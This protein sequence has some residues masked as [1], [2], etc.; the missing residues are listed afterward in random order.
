MD[1]IQLLPDTVANQIAAGE[2]IERPAS[3]IKELVENAIDAEAR[4]IDVLVVDA[5]RTLIKVVDDGKGMSPIDA[6]KSFE[7]HATSKIRKADDLFSLHTMGFRGEALA[8]IAAVSQVE[9]RTRQEEDVVGTRI[10]IA[11]SKV[12]SQEVV[13]CP[14]GSSFSVNNIFFNIPA[15]RKFLKSDAAELNNILSIFERI[16]LV[17]PDIAF[18]FHIGEMEKYNLRTCQRMQRIVDIF[19]GRMQQD[20]V[21]VDVKTSVCN[22]SGFVGKPE[23]AKKKA[24]KQFF[25]VNGRYMKHPYFHRAVLQAVERMIPAG[26]QIPYFLYL[27]VNPENIDVNVSPTKTDIKFENEQTIWQI[28]NV[29]VKDSIGTFSD[30]P[31]IDFDVENRPDIPVFLDNR[32]KGVPKPNVNTSSSYNPFSNNAETISQRRN[33]AS[34][35]E[36]FYEA[37]K[38]EG[39]Q[40]VSVQLS[41]VKYENTSLWNNYSEDVITEKGNT[42]L[43]ED[44]SSVHYQYKGTYIITAV[45]SGLLVIDQH[46]A[47]L[48]VLYERFMKQ[49]ENRT[50]PS[51]KVLFPEVLTFYGNDEATLLSILDDLT[52]LGFD[53]T[54]LGGGS[55]AVNGTP[56]DIQ[57]VNVIKLL[58]D[59]VASIEATPKETVCSIIAERLAK[60]AAITYGELL[61]DK[62]MEKLVADLFICSN[63]N[64]TPSGKTIL[65]IIEDLDER[66]NR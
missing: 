43:I 64:Y 7:H 19:G 41:N 14:K 40:N 53:I 35:W 17:Y 18:T 10:I 25:F 11:G 30:S 23:S 50:A 4:H 24:A 3:V 21:P 55:Y 58:Q 20:L 33:G 51:Q 46:R 6:R 1:I 36:S 5:G 62:E 52:M 42:R 13:S 47:H 39:I 37:L 28:I 54:S 60:H 61:D 66:F 29:A 59:I 12:E 63:V 38:K 26:E 8:T 32:D 2:V 34:D 56:A 16:A 22:L 9:L 65:T 27:D 57:G 48:R 44:K 31:V 49:I 45:K 15:R